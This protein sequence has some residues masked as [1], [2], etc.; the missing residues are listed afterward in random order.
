MEEDSLVERSQQ[1]DP[2]AVAELVR[3]HY[4]ISLRIARS[5]VRNEHDAE[6]VVQSAYCKAIQHLGTFRRESRFGSWMT[7]IVINNA[8]ALLRSRHSRQIRLENRVQAAEFTSF[9]AP[10]ST[11]EE[12]F[13]AGEAA[14]LLQ[15][16]IS[17][18]PLL[19]RQTCQLRLQ[20]LTI[21][22]IS[23]R[24]QVKVTT[25]RVRQHRAV[26]LLRTHLQAVRSI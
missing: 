10:E 12:I 14:M 18:L 23:A 19:S 6:D 16:A 9:V 1:G 26:R 4:Q 25:V 8:F 3:R 21:R 7:R 15:E 11:P 13:E 22:D 24:M 5:I 17:N 20:D 2:D